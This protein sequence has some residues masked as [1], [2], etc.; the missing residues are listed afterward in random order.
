[1]RRVDPPFA[2]AAWFL[3]RAATPAAGFFARGVGVRQSSRGTLTLP[4]TLR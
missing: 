4:L 2:P 1:M 3:P